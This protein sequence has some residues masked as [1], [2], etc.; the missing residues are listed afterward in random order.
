MTKSAH[1]L[2]P[3]ELDAGL[4]K[5][6]I[7]TLRV[8]ISRTYLD[9]VAAGMSHDDAVEEVVKHLLGAQE[10]WI[11]RTLGRDNKRILGADH[12]KYE[13]K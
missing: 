12:Y 3:A 1:D 7:D 6:A 11:M 4:R 10:R 5:E 13:P 9:G 2:T 8:I